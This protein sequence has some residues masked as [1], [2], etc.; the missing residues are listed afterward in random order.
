MPVHPGWVFGGGGNGTD[1]GA[2]FDAASALYQRGRPDYPTALIDTVIEVTGI[3]AGD[4]LLEVGCATYTRLDEPIPRFSQL[5]VGLTD[6]EAEVVHAD[7]APLGDGRRVGTYLDQ[8]QLMVRPVRREVG[9]WEARGRSPALSF[10]PRT[11]P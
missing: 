11:S 2:T 10:K 5:L 9:G 8:E 6:L 3:R 1:L 7:P 4:Q